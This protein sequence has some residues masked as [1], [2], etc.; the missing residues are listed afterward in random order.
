M[1]LTPFALMLADI[2]YRKLEKTRLMMR[3][4]EVRPGSSREMEI[5]LSGHTVICGHGQV[6]STLARVLKRR[7]L[8]YMVIDLDPQVIARLR[9]EGVP[10][11]YGDTSNPDILAHAQLEKAKLL[12][13]T[14]PGFIDIELTAKYARAINP[15]LDVVARVQR[16]QD[17]AGLKTAGVN[18]LVQP[19]FE[20]SLEITRHALHR[21]GLSGNEI[22]IILNTLRQQGGAA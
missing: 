11:I 15:K 19:E 14:I 6:G 3:L 4:L 22:Q 17:I 8:S 21:Y 12:V 13:C 9:A 1:V 20:A 7:N 18:E 2:I 16:D 10:C 5:K